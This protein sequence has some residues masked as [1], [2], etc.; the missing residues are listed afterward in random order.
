MASKILLLLL[1]KKSEVFEEYMKN[2]KPLK[3]LF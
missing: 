2:K 3:H 1:N